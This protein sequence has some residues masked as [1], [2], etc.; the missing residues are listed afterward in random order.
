MDN[1]ENK[2]SI[3][4]KETSGI[5]MAYLGD[6]VWELVVR[7]YFIEKGLSILNL[8]K[9]VITFVNAKK[10]S[11]IFKEIYPTLEEE[12]QNVGRRARNAN[13]KSFPKTCNKIEYREATAF[14]AIIGALY[15]NDKKYIIEKIIER[16]VEEE[17]N[18]L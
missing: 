13:I 8:N 3:N 1:V 18:G 11:K 9:K 2:K 5:V 12:Y 10:Q 16:F 15:L 17:K 7:K 14:E 6:A 4:T